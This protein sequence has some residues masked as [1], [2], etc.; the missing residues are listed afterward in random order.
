[1][2]KESKSNKK[3]KLKPKS[4]KTKVKSKNKTKRNPIDEMLDA[5]AV[6]PS[7]K[8][9]KRSEEEI[10]DR[11]TL[12]GI[13]RLLKGA[14]SDVKALKSDDD[15]TLQ[16]KVNEAIQQLPPAEVVKQLEA[17]DPEKLVNTL[18]LDCLGIFVDFS[19]VSCVRCVDAKSC[20]AKF[21]SNVQGGFAHLKGAAPSAEATKAKVE[22]VK[23]GIVPVTRYEKNRLVFVRDVDNP[24]PKGDD[25]H[26]TFN[27]I[28][29][30]Q[31]ETLEQLRDLVEE[32]FDFDGDGDFMKFVT[33]IRDPG[34]GIIK[35]DVDL[36]DKDKVA[37][38]AAGYD[39]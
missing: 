36:T 30:E 3:S 35:L 5:M 21:I 15:A 17:L 28:L 7:P 34:E 2:K 12:I 4:A 19:D 32:D 27:S 33:A 10:M 16:R 24:N 9:S 38:R 6:A 20:V 23:A 26:D 37:L 13:A 39:V 18:K 31:P 14:G 8:V 25:Y 22:P 29:A 1:V 11:P